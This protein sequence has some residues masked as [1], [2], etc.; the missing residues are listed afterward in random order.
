MI[1]I[2]VE[3]SITETNKVKFE[4]T[5]TEVANS[6]TKLNGCLEYYWFKDKI[7]P[8]HYFVYGEFSDMQAFLNYKKSYV[9]DTIINQLIPLTASKPKYKHFEAIVFEEG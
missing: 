1:I 2:K 9:V 7:L 4:E 6:A 3:T 5:L 8:N